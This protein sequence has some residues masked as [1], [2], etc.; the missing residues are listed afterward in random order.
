MKN[1]ILE[2]V[3]QTASGLHKSGTIADVTMREFDRLCL[4]PVHVLEEK[5]GSGS[6]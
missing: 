2:V 1:L 5:I 6:K 3:H 4:K